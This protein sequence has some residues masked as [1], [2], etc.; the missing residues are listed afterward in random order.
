MSYTPGTKQLHKH[1]YVNVLL[2]RPELNIWLINTVTTRL[3]KILIQ[4]LWKQSP[5]LASEK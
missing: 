5:Y 4:L 2:L 3:L 1:C